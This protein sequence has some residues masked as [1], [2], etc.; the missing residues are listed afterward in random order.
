[1]FKALVIDKQWKYEKYGVLDKTHL[2]FFTKK[3]ILEMFE[4]L[5]YNVLSLDGI[6]SI[7]PWKVRLLNMLLFGALSD[8]R[9]LEFACVAKP[10]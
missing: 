2:R 5:G 9:Y 4:M 7:W 6:N 10:K 3:S 1:V 8:T